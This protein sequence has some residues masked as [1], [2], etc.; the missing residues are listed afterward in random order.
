MC[1][2]NRRI[3][4]LQ[5]RLRLELGN[6]QFVVRLLHSDAGFGATALVTVKKLQRY[7]DTDQGDRF[8]D[9]VVMPHPPSDRK[10]RDGL[11]LGQAQ[12]GLA[13]G[14]A[15]SPTGE[16]WTAREALFELRINGHFG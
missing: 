14:D 12:L 8:A 13:F 5:C 15:G 2:D 1:A 6:P 10:V 16:R 7:G 11:A 4:R 9:I 3:D